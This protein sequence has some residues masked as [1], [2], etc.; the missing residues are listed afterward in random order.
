MRTSALFGAKN[1]TLYFS[2]FMVYLHEQGGGGRGLSQCGSHFAD[3]GVNFSRFC[4]D[5]FYGRPLTTIQK[6][7]FY[8]RIINKQVK[9]FSHKISQ[10]GKSTVTDLYVLRHKKRGTG[11]INRT[12]CK[13]EFDFCHPFSF[14]VGSI[15]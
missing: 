1:K 5:V 12:L 7:G 13:R 10:I 2:K 4:A 8:F 15:R 11:N 3:G 9:I 14:V 6:K